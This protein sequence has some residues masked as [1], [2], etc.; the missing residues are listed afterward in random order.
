MAASQLFT[1]DVNDKL[2]ILDSTIPNIT[3]QINFVSSQLEDAG[4]VESLVGLMEQ[5]NGL[6]QELEQLTIV[7]SHA[8]AASH[9]SSFR[10]EEIVGAALGE[11]VELALVDG[12]AAE[13]IS[14]AALNAAAATTFTKEFAVQL[15]TT[16]G[17]IHRWANHAPTVTPA[18]SCT[19]TE[20]GDPAVTQVGGATAAFATGM[21]SL[22]VTFDT[23]AGATK[24]YQSGDSLTVTVD[25]SGVPILANVSNFVKTYNVIA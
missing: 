5:L 24:T 14:A 11:D 6:K 13:D 8:T 16:A 19:D 22:V 20:I 21:L 4:V 10:L 2:K 7:S 18:E 15:Q 3:E 25:V 1:I 23:D 12:T 17:I 9:S